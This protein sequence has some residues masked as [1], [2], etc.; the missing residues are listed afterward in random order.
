MAR[1]GCGTGTGTFALLA[2]DNIIVSGTGTSASPWVVSS[3]TDPSG[4]RSS[5]TASDGVA[6]DSLTGE[7]TACVSPNVGNGLSRDVNGCLFVGAGNNSVIT[8]NGLTGNGLTGNPLTIR[9]KAWPFTCPQSSATTMGVY[10]DRVTG[11]LHSDPQV[12][13]AQFQNGDDFIPPAPIVV[14]SAADVPVHAVSLTI[15]NPDP[16][17]TAKVM[18]WRDVD[19]DLD[20]PPASGGSY[21]IDSDDMAHFENRGISTAFATHTQT[22][23]M[24]FTTIAAG[25]TAVLAHN[26]TAG[27][28]SGGASISR[29]RTSTR[30]W[31][32]SNP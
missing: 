6:F 13:M 26:V 11:L 8:G 20:L 10:A 14:P 5:L 24:T 30:A 9:G 19:V 29:I 16:C 12:R 18:L 17:R 32:I 28:G 15:T 7:I 31:V 25:A 2:G 4:V 1:C 27:L 23:K 3:S 21:G 22:G